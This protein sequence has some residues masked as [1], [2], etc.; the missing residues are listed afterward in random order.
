MSNRAC[1]WSLIYVVLATWIGVVAGLHLDEQPW[2]FLL[3]LLLLV[4]ALSIC[5]RRCIDRKVH[6]PRHKE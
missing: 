3:S 5:Y 2:T 4:V 1:R 6:T